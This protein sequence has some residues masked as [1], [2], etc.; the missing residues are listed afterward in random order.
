MPVASVLQ[1]YK[2][3]TASHGQVQ[4][5]MRPPPSPPPYRLVT[6][7]T[8]GKVVLVAATRTS[9]FIFL[10]NLHR[11]KYN[12]QNFHSGPFRAVKK[13]SLRDLPFASMEF[14]GQERLTA[15][16]KGKELHLGIRTMS[17]T[18]ELTRNDFRSP[19]NPRRSEQVIFL[20]GCKIRT[21][22]RASRFIGG[23]QPS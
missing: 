7:I 19:V 20:N 2:I 10:I 13:C 18:R 3:S 22:S 16:V 17:G 4:F 14:E 23:N 9:R 12:I 5:F 15:N 8:S 11:E 1:L 6:D 21:E